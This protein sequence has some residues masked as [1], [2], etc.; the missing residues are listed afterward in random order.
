MNAK[1]KEIQF[2]DEDV[3]NLDD[4]IPE[5]QYNPHRV[6]PW[7]IH[8]HGFTIAVVFAD[9]AQDALDEAVDNHKLDAF[10]IEEKGNTP[11]TKGRDVSDYPTLG[12]ENEEGIT[13]L[14]NASEPFDIETLG[15]VEMPNPKASFAAQFAASQNSSVSQAQR[16]T[17]T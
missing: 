10:L 15:I 9:C 4:W 5:G 1:Y 6:R 3:V 8:D 12:T 2:S 14:G 16:R 17:K 13:R 7:L 11:G